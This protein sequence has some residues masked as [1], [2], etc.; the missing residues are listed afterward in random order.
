MIAY[1][2]IVDWSIKW[3]N[4]VSLQSELQSSFASTFSELW[5]EFTSAT[6]HIKSSLN[7]EWHLQHLF[8]SEAHTIA[9]NDLKLTAN[10]HFKVRRISCWSWQLR[11][12]RQ[13][14]D[15]QTI[16]SNT[17]MN[18]WQSRRTLGKFAM[19]IGFD[20]CHR[21]ANRNFLIQTKNYTIDGV[22]FELLMSRKWLSI[23]VGLAVVRIRTIHTNLFAAR[24]KWW[25]DKM[26]MLCTT[27]IH[28]RSPT[29][30]IRVSCVCACVWVYEC[31]YQ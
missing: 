3:P 25:H 6:L 27:P 2:F 9:Q 31:M 28:V 22:A 18:W 13:H 26:Q 14:N 29:A 30:N 7:D 15:T 4:K 24:Y 10:F 1:D 23:C 5:I 19:W 12:Y 8:G 16:F 20:W 17:K 11:A 21:C